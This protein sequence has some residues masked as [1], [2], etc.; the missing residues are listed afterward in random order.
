[1]ICRCSKNGLFTRFQIAYKADNV[2]FSC[3]RIWDSTKSKVICILWFH[4][5]YLFH[6]ASLIEVPL[7]ITRCPNGSS[8][9]DSVL[10]TTLSNKKT[11]HFKQ[12]VCCYKHSMFITC[13]GNMLLCGMSQTSG[14]AACVSHA[15]IHCNI[16]LYESMFIACLHTCYVTMYD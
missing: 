2:T 8:S 11:F 14:M 16:T 13:C 10:S 5:L 4:Y 12:H 15:V 6:N 1:M 9:V 3:N 7:F